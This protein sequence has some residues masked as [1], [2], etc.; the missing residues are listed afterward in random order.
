MK[1]GRVR[2]DPQPPIRSAPGDSPQTPDDPGFGQLARSRALGGDKTLVLG[3]IAVPW[4]PDLDMD[5]KFHVR[6]PPPARAR[7]ARLQREA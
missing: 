3:A 5:K 4:P 1:R 2:R 6:L 7:R